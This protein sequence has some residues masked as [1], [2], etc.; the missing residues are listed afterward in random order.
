MTTTQ[1]PAAAQRPQGLSARPRLLLLCLAALVGAFGLSVALTALLP[2][3]QRAE[4][5]EWGAI[6]LF[7]AAAIPLAVID[8]RTRRLPNRGTFPLA[9]A[10]LG[11]WAG[12]AMTTGSWQ[13]L[14]QAIVT[15]ISIVAA[16]FLIALFGTLAAGD[17]KL[18]I[19]I[20]LLTGWFSWMLPVYAL[21]ASYLLAIPHAA[22]I[23]ARRRHHDRDTRL[24]FGPYLVAA[25][26]L[27]AV[28]AKLFT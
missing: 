13:L 22:A 19:A 2:A 27:A 4:A 9:A 20:A 11:Y 8:A 18:L 7:A 26:I 24:P 1:Q 12:I 25:A 14:I 23:L 28:A 10:T 6:I 21:F 16:V 17:V 3:F 5:G 15:T